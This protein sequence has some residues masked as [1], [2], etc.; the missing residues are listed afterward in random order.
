[1]SVAICHADWIAAIREPL[2]VPHV[3]HLVENWLGKELARWWFS[4]AA[5]DLMRTYSSRLPGQEAAARHWEQPYPPLEP[6]SGG[7]W[8]VFADA[9]GAAGQLLKP[10]FLMPLQW[11]PSS[12]EEPDHDPFLPRSVVAVANEA[13]TLLTEQEPDDRFKA[14]YQRFRLWFPKSLRPLV[15][16]NDVELPAASGAIT[17]ITAL[18]LRVREG[19][20]DPSIWAS[21]AW[22]NGVQGVER[23]DLKLDLAAK[24]L[25][26]GAIVACGQKAKESGTI[27]FHVSAADTSQCVVPMNVTLNALTQGTRNFFDAVREFRLAAG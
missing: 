22:N 5:C 12:V 15:S 11:R 4:E 19:R 16:L 14:A 27:D 20:P 23:L 25:K 18:L 6:E 3:R 1:M 7:C 2:K 9:A 17:I 8:V 21:A 10:A 26:A 13:I 24:C